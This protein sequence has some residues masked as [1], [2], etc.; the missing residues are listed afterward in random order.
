[1]SAAEQ[2]YLKITPRRQIA[3]DFHFERIVKG[4]DI[5]Q[6]FVGE[7]PLVGCLASMLAVFTIWNKEAFQISQGKLGYL[8]FKL[9]PQLGA[10][11]SRHTVGEALKRLQT[12]GYIVIPKRHDWGNKQ[13]K[14]YTITHEL[15]KIT[16]G[17]VC[18]NNLHAE[19]KRNNE[20]RRK[21]QVI[22]K[23]DTNNPIVTKT[24][25]RE[26]KTNDETTPPR[27]KLKIVSEPKRE[28]KQQPKPRKKYRNWT[29]GKA[30]ERV[31][32]W[33]TRC[34]FFGSDSERF[35]ALLIFAE[36]SKTD[37][38]LAQIL[39][40]WPEATNQER[41]W[42]TRKVVEHLKSELEND[43]G[44]VAPVVPLQIVKPEPVEPP[45]TPKPKP[46]KILH[47][48]E[49][50]TEIFKNALIWGLKKTGYNGPGASFIDY[51]WQLGDNSQTAVIEKIQ[52][53]ETLDLRGFK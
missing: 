35:R 50:D 24:I 51:F 40:K 42:L 7:R 3:R 20:K 14:T 23:L 12:L 34:D 22:T 27:G 10:Q 28:P 19:N 1:M 41:S 6:H 32:Y 53:G 37:D 36:T 45:E 4:Q 47:E 17:Q 33:L 18:A 9:F 16:P 39:A 29:P 13:T 2:L 48:Q 31:R 44:P 15:R 52:R 38:W 43:P 49:I 46:F 26:T 25:A 8:V 11:P 21:L 30:Y 5:F